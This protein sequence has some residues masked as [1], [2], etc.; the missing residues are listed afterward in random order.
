MDH[1]VYF[2]KYTAVYGEAAS[3]KTMYVREMM[4]LL[5]PHVS[6]WHIVGETKEYEGIPGCSVVQDSGLGVGDA[7]ALN[8]GIIVDC[9]N[10]EIARV[11]NGKHNRFTT[12]FF[13]FTSPTDAKP[14]LRHNMDIHVFTTADS[15]TSFFAMR[16]NMIDKQARELS[17]MAIKECFDQ[18]TYK[19]LMYRQNDHDVFTVIG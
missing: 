2:Q 12:G 16:T 1:K 11:L 6:V 18:P 4:K 15:A 13:L 14:V 3:G 5:Q 8:T 9:A 10:I 17:V 19:K 7:P